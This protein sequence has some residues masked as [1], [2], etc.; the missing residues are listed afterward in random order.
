MYSN[1]SGMYDEGWKQGRLNMASEV[2]I[3]N[4]ALPLTMS[5][6]LVK[7]SGLVIKL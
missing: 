7:T 5:D 6:A 4:H 2:L 3:T 1:P